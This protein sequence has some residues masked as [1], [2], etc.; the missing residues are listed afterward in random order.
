MVSEAFI[1]WETSYT[2]MIFTISND[3]RYAEITQKFSFVENRKMYEYYNSFLM[4]ITIGEILKI[5]FNTPKAEDR[6]RQNILH[7][8]S[9][10]SKYFAYSIAD[11]DVFVVD[12]LNLETRELNSVP[13]TFIFLSMFPKEKY[14][15]LSPFVLSELSSNIIII[16]FKSSI[17][18]QNLIQETIAIIYKHHSL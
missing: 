5:L 16:D 4:D 12:L 2:T 7:S 1:T 14:L 6:V 13:K 11:S 10:N 8:F 17:F 3:F 15:G 18:L 9:P